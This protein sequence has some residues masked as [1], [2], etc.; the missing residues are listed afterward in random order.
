MK[1]SA[2]VTDRK[3]LVD[4]LNAACRRSYT[5]LRQDLTLEFEQNLVKTYL[6]EAHPNGEAGE[7][8]RYISFL[9]D[10]LT[11]LK[12]RV[13]ET[14]D[15]SLV[16]LIGDS[17]QFYVDTYSPRYWMFHTVSRSD[18]SDRLIRDIVRS[19]PQL[20]FPWLPIQSLENL[21]RKGA[22]VGF[23]TD[24]DSVPTLNL[25]GRRNPTIQ[26]ESMGFRLRRASGTVDEDYRR[27]RQPAMYGDTLRLSTIR[28]QYGEKGVSEDYS[29]DEITYWGKLTARGPSFDCHNALTLLMMEDYRNQIDT[30]EKACLMRFEETDTGTRIHGYP[31]SI[32]YRKQPN[33]HVFVKVLFSG[34][35]P[36]K[37]WG[38]PERVTDKLYRIQAVDLHGGST[39]RFE[40]ADSFL[41][42]YLS[43]NACANTVAR[44]FSNLQQHVD[45]RSL[46]V[47]GSGD[48]A[49]ER[50]SQVA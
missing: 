38:V 21:A 6:I 47:L 29:V 5:K 9:V 11:P 49:F 32:Q 20:D 13:Q 50:A 10:Q 27:L 14:N 30:I 2:R 22:F 35:E 25:T 23:G 8:E 17:V 16:V 1:E 19:A 31:I 33:L 45:S 34:G 24:F 37:L 7:Y 39:V 3:S 26:G 4:L 18:S 44:L 36:F 15:P 28:V 40:V 48:K 12:V 43:R 42:I 41:R 46:L